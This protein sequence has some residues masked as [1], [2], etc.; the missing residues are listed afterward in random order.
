MTTLSTHQPEAS[1]STFTPTPKH[2]VSL[3]ICSA[4]AREQYLRLV[5]ANGIVHSL[6]Q[7]L[8]EKHGGEKH[9]SDPTGGCVALTRSYSFD[10]KSFQMDNSMLKTQRPNRSIVRDSSLPLRSYLL[11]LLLLHA[12]LCRSTLPPRG[13][14]SSN[15][16]TAF[17]PSLRNHI[18]QRK[19]D[20]RHA[21]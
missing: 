3:V 6:V 9:V 2:H 20:A 7:R 17:R 18:N 11:Y 1:T 4:L 10:H 21:C 19:G 15:L 5:E 16:V 13:I 8:I 12:C 14:H